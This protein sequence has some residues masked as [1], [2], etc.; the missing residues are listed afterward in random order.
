MTK[1][2]KAKSPIFEAVHE[3]AADLQRLGFIDKHNMYKFDAMC[4]DRL[5]GRADRTRW[6]CDGLKFLKKFAKKP[7][8]LFGYCVSSYYFYRKVKVLFLLRPHYNTA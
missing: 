1:K 2:A 6:C 7:S 3:T 4:L 8:S 5:F